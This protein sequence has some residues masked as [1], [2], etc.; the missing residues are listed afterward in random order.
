MRIWL[1]VSLQQCFSGRPWKAHW[2]A[3]VSYPR[4]SA[5]SVTMY[6]DL[7][8]YVRC[9]WI[10]YTI[11]LMARCSRLWVFSK[12]LWTRNSQQRELLFISPGKGKKYINLF[13]LIRSTHGRIWTKARQR[14]QNTKRLLYLC[15]ISLSRLSVTFISM[16]WWYCQKGR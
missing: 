10:L 7:R 16:L 14:N 5:L 13:V 12:E 1:L 3:I 9:I 15:A 6:N 8:S 4:H 11:S 2:L